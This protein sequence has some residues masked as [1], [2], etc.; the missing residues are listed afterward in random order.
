MERIMP[1]HS[2]EEA[3]PPH[4]QEEVHGLQ[5]P[6]HQDPQPTSTIEANPAQQPKKMPPPRRNGGPRL[7]S[8][9]H[10]NKRRSQCV[11]CYDE[12]TGGSTICQHRRQRYAVSCRIVLKIVHPPWLHCAY[13]LGGNDASCPLF[14]TLERSGASHPNH[15]HSLVHLLDRLPFFDTLCD[16]SPPCD[17]SW[18]RLSEIYRID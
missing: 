10:H 9:C 17:L 2:F 11:K 1:I 3:V 7:S 14:Q 15:P 8:I 5:V 12:G 6:Q 4:H 13:P 18:L 16:C